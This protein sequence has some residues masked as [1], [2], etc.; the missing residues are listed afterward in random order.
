MARGRGLPVALAR[1]EELETSLP[2]KAGL[3]PTKKRG[4]VIWHPI[5][6]ELQHGTEIALILR[7]HGLPTLELEPTTG[8]AGAGAVALARGANTL[9][10]WPC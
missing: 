9:H 8:S 1:P 2:V 3:R 4:R 10:Q 6:H 7:Q 5:E